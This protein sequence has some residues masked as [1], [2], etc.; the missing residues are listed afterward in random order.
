MAMGVV[1]CEMEAELDTR[2]AAVGEAGSLSFMDAFL[3]AAR[4]VALG[5]DRP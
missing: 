4:E 1:G 2:E 5:G 3:C